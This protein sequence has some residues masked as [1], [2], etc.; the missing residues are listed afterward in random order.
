MLTFGLRDTVLARKMYDFEQ[1][2][3]GK[4]NLCTPGDIMM[5]LRKLAEGG[6]SSNSTS[7]EMLSI[8]EQQQYREKIP[9]KL[10]PE[11]KIANK[12]GSVPG[13]VHDV[14]VVSGADWAYVICV[15]TKCV[16]DSSLAD[17]AIAEV[18][19]A[20]YDRFQERSAL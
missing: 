10:P 18:S 2:K 7:N 3:R 5:L 20:I 1:I 6:I 17:R 14:A 8:M 16:V 19:R 9:R 12:T 13:V 11:L 4:E 15:M